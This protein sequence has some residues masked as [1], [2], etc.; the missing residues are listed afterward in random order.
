MSGLFFPE[1]KLVLPGDGFSPSSL[2]LGLSEAVDC[3][4]VFLIAGVLCLFGL[5]C[6]S[7]KVVN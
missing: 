1:E 3:L 4:S 2:H 7:L 5:L 6:F